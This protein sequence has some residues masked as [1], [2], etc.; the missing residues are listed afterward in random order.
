[1]AM[2]SETL[3]FSVCQEVRGAMH[4]G[5]LR[6]SSQSLIFKDTTTGKSDTISMDDVADVFWRRV[7]RGYQL[8]FRL[9][10]GKIKKYDGFKEDHKQKVYDFMNTQLG[11]EMETQELS[12]KGWNWG[13]AEVG[14]DE[15]QFMT[16]DGKI[17]FDIMLG[18]VSNCVQNKN[19]V[20]LEFHQNESTN[21]VTMMEC[22]FHLPLADENEDP[23]ALLC[24]KVLSK[25]DVIQAKGSA[26]TQLYKVQCL[27]PRGRYDVKIYPTFLHLHGKTFDFKL[28]YTSIIRLF[29]LPHKDHR[30]VFFVISVDPPIKQGNARY[31]FIICLFDKDQMI[32]LELE[33]DDEELKQKFDGKLQRTMSGA[34]FEV[35]S[36]LMKA[37]T[38]RKITVP[39]SYKSDQ[40]SSCI[41]CNYRAQTGVLFPLERGFM[42]L[43]KPPIYLR[44]DEIDNVNF[45]RESTKNRSFE[46]Q[47]E[48]KT[49]TKYTF[50]TID[51]SEYTSLFDFSKSH[52]LK[53]RNIGASHKELTNNPADL[54]SDSDDNFDSYRNV[55]GNDIEGMGGSDE[56]S[57][58]EDFNPDDAD[59][60]AKTGGDEEFDSDFADR[61]TD[62]EDRGSDASIDPEKAARRAEKAERRKKKEEKKERK[63][64]EG[65]GSSK[66][67]KK[68]REKK[69]KNPGQPKRGLSSYMFFAA[70]ARV[71]IK[72]DQPSAS[73]T[74]IAKMIG[75]RWNKL[76]AEE[77][78]PYEEKAAKDK[79]RYQEE[80]EKFKREGGVVTGPTKKKK[81]A[82]EGG[83]S[84][85]PTKPPSAPKTSPAKA[86][87][88][89]EEIS[90]SG[91]DSD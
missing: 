52:G 78:A 40:G 31:P 67:P 49:G 87:K 68:K 34:M 46:F 86:H 64:P 4:E 8:K 59:P 18:N 65:G 15:L 81:K 17:A 41:S 20:T 58:D 74:E 75:E 91:S 79:Q 29:L 23:A 22:R 16:D 32:D 61:S 3:D 28:T 77:K 83:E 72:A 37:V 85:K 43:H 39:G 27:T 12:C 76:T 10:S 30:Q 2:A 66:E 11:K 53:I 55:I 56:S 44:F 90:D 19:E 36:L 54:S 73:V 80:M 71:T 89:K 88:S 21:E 60:E 9:E 63:R 14:G 7:A 26:I 47:V 69:E 6:L 82:T 1:M 70:D 50:G 25:A 33:L 62:S 13:R 45:A 5:R 42:Y 24:E 84:S 35:V 51:R 38:S 48:A 57:T